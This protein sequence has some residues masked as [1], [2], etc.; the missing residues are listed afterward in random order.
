[1]AFPQNL[2]IVENIHDVTS[3][4][5]RL[6]SVHAT[7][8]TYAYDADTIV[9]TTLASFQF[10][11]DNDHLCKKHHAFVIGVNSDVS[12]RNAGI[13]VQEDQQTRALKVALPLALQHPDRTIAVI[14]YDEE[15]PEELY[16][17]LRH[18]V[19]ADLYTL[20]K[21]GYGTAPNAPKIIGSDH[22]EFT[23][24]F[25]LP[26]DQKPVFYDKTPVENQSHVNVYK[27]SGGEGRFGHYLSDAGKITFPVKDPSL[28]RHTEDYRIRSLIDVGNVTRTALNT[29]RTFKN[30]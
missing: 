15:T 25:P 14:Y 1:M 3:P 16:R 6:T 2:H 28:E 4:I 22:F 24:G 20:H 8:G 5:G 30:E 9:P 18:D 11:A 10:I 19:G 21:W 29:D 12:M 7:N 26:N 27:L 13:D 23:F 17:A